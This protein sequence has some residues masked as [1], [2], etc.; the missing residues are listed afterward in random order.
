MT[1]YVRKY[2]TRVKSH[3][4]S[5]GW[6]WSRAVWASVGVSTLTAA[7]ILW[8]MGAAVLATLCVVPITLF[9]TVPVVAGK[10]AEK[11]IK[12]MHRQQRRRR[13]S[14]TR[15]TARR[16]A[17]GGRRPAVGR[18]GDRTPAETAPLPRR[19]GGGPSL[20]WRLLGAHSSHL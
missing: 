12:T 16:A 13:A 5:A 8:E 19:R 3:T 20:S 15:W 2:G 1:S 6:V 4:R 11:N 9:S 18:T 7:G 17:A 14:R 10:Y